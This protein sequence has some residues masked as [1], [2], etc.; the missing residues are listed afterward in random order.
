MKQ[1]GKPGVDA[2][3]V[4]KEAPYTRDPWFLTAIT[5]S[6]PRPRAPSAPTDALTLSRILGYS[7]CFFEEF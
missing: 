6:Q 7:C 1:E 4:K 2:K 5:P 3:F